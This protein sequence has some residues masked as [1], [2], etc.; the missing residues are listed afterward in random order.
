MEGITVS[1]YHLFAAGQEPTKVD[2]GK[3]SLEEA[4]II[5]NE[6]ELVANVMV[7]EEDLRSSVGETEGE[8]LRAMRSEA[9]AQQPKNVEV[10]DSST[11]ESDEG[12]SDKQTEPEAMVD[13]SQPAA[14]KDNLNDTKDTEE[15][16][17][18]ADH[19]DVQGRSKSDLSNGGLD[20]SECSK[21]ETKEVIRHDI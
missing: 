7:A 2:P 20:Q 11:T 12:K 6:N 8:S 15:I 10:A 16:R 3:R 13:F 5:S 9:V 21:G 19:E 17:N 18:L 1:C 14:K 4:N